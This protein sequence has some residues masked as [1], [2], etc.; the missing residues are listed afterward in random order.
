MTP[1]HFGNIITVTVCYAGTLYVL[2]IIECMKCM[3]SIRGGRK[4]KSLHCRQQIQIDFDVCYTAMTAFGC[5]AQHSQ[6][7]ARTMSAKSAALPPP[8]LTCRKSSRNCVTATRHVN[9]RAL[10]HQYLSASAGRGDHRSPAQRSTYCN[11]IRAV[12]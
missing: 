1:R 11:F 12:P 7:S 8:R 10:R 2:Y 3:N 5:T 6:H 4:K 9:R